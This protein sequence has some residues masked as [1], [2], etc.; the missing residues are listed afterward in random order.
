MDP[1]QHQT[2]RECATRHLETQINDRRIPVICWD[3][4]CGQEL[5]ENNISALVSAEVWDL[6]THLSRIP[7]SDPG[8]K[9]CPRPDC[10]GYYLVDT[11]GPDDG[12][13]C[14]V[15]CAHRWCWCCQVSLVESSQHANISCAEYQQWKRDNDRGDEAM[16]ALLRAGLMDQNSPDRMRRCPRCSYPWMKDQACM[17]HVVCEK[18]G[19]GCG[20]HFCFQCADYHARGAMDIYNHQSACRGY[21]PPNRP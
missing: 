10:R 20:V 12:A 11:D 19:G 17:S 7:T 2:C 16:E 15:G 13:C 1:C 8:F 9:Q 14:C 21:Q 3:P 6:A 4:Q 5:A 18:R